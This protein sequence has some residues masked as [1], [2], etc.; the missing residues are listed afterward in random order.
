MRAEATN[1]TPLSL[2]V[3]KKSFAGRLERSCVNVHT[4]DTL[5]AVLYTCG[6]YDS[7]TSFCTRL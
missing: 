5:G 6:G 7:V 4:L 3:Q 1:D 2:D